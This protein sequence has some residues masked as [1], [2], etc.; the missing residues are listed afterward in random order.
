MG[1]REIAR[2]TDG[3]ANSIGAE[4][5]FATAKPKPWESQPYNYEAPTNDGSSLR[6]DP[7]RDYVEQNH[8]PHLDDSTPF[9]DDGDHGYGSSVF[10]VTPDFHANASFAD[11]QGTLAGCWRR[12]RTKTT[13]QQPVPP[14]PDPSTTIP[15]MSDRE[16]QMY[17]LP[18]I[19]K[20]S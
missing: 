8:G 13:D 6:C 18:P 1:P 11:N 3:N 2:L 14:P 16:R 20:P 12:P 9:N 10:G 7:R 17:V 15:S 4:K 5:K 19:R